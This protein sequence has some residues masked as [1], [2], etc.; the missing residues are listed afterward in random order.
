MSQRCSKCIYV[1]FTQNSNSSTNLWD[2]ILACHNTNINIGLSI[3]HKW[4]NGWS[5]GQNS[6]TTETLKVVITYKLSTKRLFFFRYKLHLLDCQLFSTF[7]PIGPYSCIKKISLFREFLS[8][9]V[10]FIWPWRNCP[11]I[12]V[13]I[14][15]CLVKQLA[16]VL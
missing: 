13:L 8:K 14:K 2:G 4:L 6:E 5:L 12:T 11:K 15:D 9:N 3:K 10:Q 16:E 7:C 1:I